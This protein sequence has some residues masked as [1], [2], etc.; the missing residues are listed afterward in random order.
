MAKKMTQDEEAKKV[1]SLEEA[2]K[3]FLACD[4]LST[5]ECNCTDDDKY[6]YSK[7]PEYIRKI[8]KYTGYYKTDDI[9]K[10]TDVYRGYDPCGND[11]SV[12]TFCIL[13]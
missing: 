6:V 13:L 11:E 9:R 3:Y 1:P 4:A 2:E 8:L 12:Y 7:I 5:V 10:Q